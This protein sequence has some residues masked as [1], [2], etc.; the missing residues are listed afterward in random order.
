MFSYDYI[1]D[2]HYYHVIILQVML[3][4]MLTHA[5][6]CIQCVYKQCEQ[7]DLDSRFMLTASHVSMILGADEYT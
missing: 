7:V 3:T 4:G 2:K 1:I 5:I 6:F